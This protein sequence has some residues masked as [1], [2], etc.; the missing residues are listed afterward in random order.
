[1]DLCVFYWGKWSME[2][3]KRMKLFSSSLALRIWDTWVQY[4]STIYKASILTLL[5][6]ILW[7]LCLFIVALR[8]KEEIRTFCHSQT[9]STK[10]RRRL[11]ISYAT[12]NNICIN[13][14]FFVVLPQIR[15]ENLFTYTYSFI[16]CK[17]FCLPNNS[18]TTHRIIINLRKGYIS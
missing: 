6:L 4:H 16:T 12:G 10:K 5:L 7:L 9:M 8:H 3:V 17:T 14:M 18:F 11:P 13:S 2:M 15:I 1:M